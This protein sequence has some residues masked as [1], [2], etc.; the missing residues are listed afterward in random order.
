LDG[1]LAAY[2][3]GHWSD[4][5]IFIRVAEEIRQQLQDEWIDDNLVD[6]YI[7]WLSVAMA[8]EDR[9]TA[10]AALAV[11]QRLCRERLHDKFALAE[12]LRADDPSLLNLDPVD[13]QKSWQWVLWFSNDRG[14][15]VS[16]DLKQYAQAHDSD[17][18][19]PSFVPAALAIKDHDATRL[20]AAIDQAEREGRIPDVARMR[21]VLAEMTGDPGPLELARPVL[22]QLQD[23]QFLRR[24]D[25]VAASLR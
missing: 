21:I 18:A 3:S 8:R 24:L 19:G 5:A 25:D 4:L 13:L 2:W 16:S 15:S 23:R 14:L 9:A 17:E 22:E 6:A 1:V 11:I 12:A 10:D 7:L 20:A